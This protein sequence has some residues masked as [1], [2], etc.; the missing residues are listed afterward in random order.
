MIPIVFVCLILGH[1]LR[2]KHIICDCLGEHI[3]RKKINAMVQGFTLH[4]L[5]DN[6]NT[7]FNIKARNQF[8]S[9]HVLAK[10][11]FSWAKAGFPEKGTS[12]SRHE[13]VKVFYA[14]VLEW[15]APDGR[16]SMKDHRD[17]WTVATML[18]STL[19]MHNM[20]KFSRTRTHIRVMIRAFGKE[21][22]SSFLKQENDNK[23][24]PV[25]VGCVFNTILNPGKF[26][27]EAQI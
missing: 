18:S 12:R 20:W 21:I 16:K 3:S 22:Q 19:A 5:V 25:Y 24:W 6:F 2:D 13:F 1:D 7:V 9:I 10:G 15:L 26:G 23:S 17:A 14:M 4:R 8:N 11:L 27:F